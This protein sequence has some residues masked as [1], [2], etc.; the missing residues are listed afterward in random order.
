VTS[1]IRGTTIGRRKFCPFI[2]VVDVSER[3]RYLKYYEVVMMDHVVAIFLTS[4][5][6]IRC[7]IQITIGL[8]FSKMLLS[9]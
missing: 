8:A 1:N 4:V 5:Q 6:H 2:V 9:M 3:M 7:Y